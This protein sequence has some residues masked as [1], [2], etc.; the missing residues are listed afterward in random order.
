M[1]FIARLISCFGYWRGS[2]TSLLEYLSPGGK[3]ID[4]LENAFYDAYIKYRPKDWPSATIYDFIEQR[5]E[6]IG[7]LDIGPVS[8]SKFPEPQ[9]F[10]P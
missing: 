9:C 2:S 4:D 8:L 7:E 5:S 6:K 3:P 1:G 10:S